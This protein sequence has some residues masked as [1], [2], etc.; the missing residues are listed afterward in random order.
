[1]PSKKETLRK[2]FYDFTEE[3]YDKETGEVKRITK[4]YSKRVRVNDFFITYIDNLSGFLK[5][6]S[7]V[8]KSVLAMLCC[9]AEYDTG[10]VFLEAKD[11]RDICENIGISVQQ[12]TNSISMLKQLK[13]LSGERGFY[14]INP[15]VYWR[16]TSKARERLLKDKAISVEFNFELDDDSNISSEIP[17]QNI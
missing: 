11:R 8:D 9:I 16:G 3:T 17:S 6:T 4:K 12:M 2:R 14:M 15:V 1:M 13:L 10:R 7:N 5:V